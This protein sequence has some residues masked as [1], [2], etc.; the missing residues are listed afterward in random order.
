MEH[1]AMRDEPEYVE[2]E[3]VIEAETDL[4]VLVSVDDDEPT[5]IPKSQVGSRETNKDGSSTLEVTEWFAIRAGL[6]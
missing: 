2:I 6:V 4:A 1:D 3:G 5:W